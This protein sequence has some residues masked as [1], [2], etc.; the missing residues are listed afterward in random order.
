[1]TITMSNLCIIPARGGSKRIPRK[2]IKDFLGKPIIAYSIE[3]AIA[4]KLFDEVI[5]STDDAEIVEVAIKYGAKVPFLRSKENANDFATT[6]SVLKE[7]ENEYINRFNKTS[8]FICCI[9]PTAPLINVDDIVNGFNLLEYNNY[10]S[11]F[12]IVSYGYPIWRGLRFGADG[13]VKMLWEKYLNARSQDLESVYHDAGQWY[14]Y[15]PTKITDTLFT[16]NS[17]SITLSEDNVQDIDNLTDWKLAEMK[18]E[19]IQNSK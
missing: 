4:S 10:S 1:M 5:V 12:P 17:S 8:D 16:E 7:V 18:Y 6:I 13:K 3:T 19:L 15:N 11:V 9:Y 2:N 14:W